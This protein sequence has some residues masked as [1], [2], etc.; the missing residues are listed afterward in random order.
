MPNHFN[1]FILGVLVS[2]LAA[3]ISSLGV[4]MQASALV[5]QRERH[6]QEELEAD[7]QVESFI[8]N[9]EEEMPLTPD[10][11]IEI[12]NNES[13]FVNID[14]ER[15]D[16]INLN[17]RIATAPVVNKIVSLQWY[18]GFLLYISC[19]VFGSGLLTLMGSDSIK[20]YSSRDCCSIGVNRSH[21][22]HDVRQNV[23]RDSYYAKRLGW[24]AANRLF[25]LNHRFQAARLFHLLVL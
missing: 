12:D 7:E 4:N 1:D 19:Q 21:I 13:P 3:L 16:S 20:F 17:L 24:N 14:S 9:I 5:Q 25:F 22:Q 2:L 18:V 15:P 23:F 11:V 10:R 6:L 8:S